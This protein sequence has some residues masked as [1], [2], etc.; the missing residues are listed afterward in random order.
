[1]SDQVNLPEKFTTANNLFAFKLFQDVFSKH[2]NKNFFISPLS[3]AINLS[4]LLNGAKDNT[5]KEIAESLNLTAF[6]QDN[7]NF[8]YQQLIQELSLS[9][10]H[11]Q[12]FIANSLWGTNWVNFYEEFLKQ[13]EEFY[14]AKLSKIDFSKPSSTK[15]I[16]DWVKDKTKGKI[17]K[18]IDQ[19]DVNTILIVLNAIYFKAE[20]QKKFNKEKTKLEA[21]YLP[22]KII[23]LCPLMFSDQEANILENKDF[24]ATNLP[25]GDGRL[26]LLLFMPKT[27]L[28]ED[29]CQTLSL[30]NYQNYFNQPWSTSNVAIPKFTLEFEIDLINHLLNL[31]ITEAFS[32]KANFS[33]LAKTTEPL[34]LNKIIQKT[35]LTVNEEGSEAAAATLSSALAAGMPSI[36]LFNQPFFYLIR[37]N[38]T[39][40]ILFMGV[41]ANPEGKD[42]TPNEQILLE[43]EEKL[44]RQ[45]GP[46]QYAIRKELEKFQKLEKSETLKNSKTLKKENLS[47]TQIAAKKTVRIISFLLFGLLLIIYWYF[48]IKQR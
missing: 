36:V 25:Y 27:L 45:L 37:D 20:W 31:A 30:E 41:L 24:I 33:L 14:E 46:F 8:Y 35:F 18:I 23:K 2:K 40:L 48:F 26:S 9:D 44:K 38:K 15:I 17:P 43:E 47:Q 7:I 5:A 42:L 28:L 19:I 10:E 12:L 16:N 1:M 4:L 6:E 21:F 29:F 13:G 3:L 34:K 39:G 32:D 11:T 22:T